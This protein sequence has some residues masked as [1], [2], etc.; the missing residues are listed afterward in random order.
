[1]I[2]RNSA[3]TILL[4]AYLCLLALASVA[5]FE[6][7]RT[8]FRLVDDYGDWRYQEIF[9]SSARLWNWL[10]SQWAFSGAQRFRPFYEFSSALLWILI[11]PRP[12][13]LH[14]IRLALKAAAA[15]FFGVCLFRLSDQK[16]RRILGAAAFFVFLAYFWFFPINPEARLSPQE[17]W[18]WLFLAW[19]NYRLFML[20][21]K[22]QGDLAA[23][24][25]ASW[26][27]FLFLFLLLAT[28]KEV[29]IAF[30]ISILLFL[31]FW[32][33]RSRRPLT[34]WLRLLTLAAALALIALKLVLALTSRS[35]DS[36]G[37]QFMPWPRLLSESILD[38]A[39]FGHRW[40]GF[41]ISGWP[42]VGIVLLA[43]FGLCFFAWRQSSFS[44]AGAFCALLAL[45][46]LC[47]WLILGF[48]QAYGLRYICPLVFPLA[49]M[50]SILCLVFLL[51]MPEA[52]RAG[53]LPL[54]VI[55]SL[56]FVL[57]NY[58]NYMYQF[59]TQYEEGRAEQEQLGVLQKEFEDGRAVTV[60][61]GSGSGGE[62][63]DKIRLYFQEF[64]PRYGGPSYSLQFKMPPT[65]DDYFGYQAQMEGYRLSGS[66]A[67]S[68]E[69][70]P[71]NSR[72]I[73]LR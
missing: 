62:M 41:L 3:K 15:G 68:G 7:L 27:G 9:D 4:L 37:L 55:G 57:F 13:L 39:P 38:L 73:C 67:I 16:E 56:Y 12:W 54:L 2:Q 23:L 33:W 71:W 20:C 44:L 51:R 28:V 50:L 35:V 45:E 36:E 25:L 29:G 30:D 17:P 14:L 18:L 60:E 5:I 19:L 52:W 21:E 34:A 8:P 61:Q 10:S 40:G 63:P 46:F 43:S 70:L 11:G 47:Y 49:G 66:Y 64:L 6:A 26:L 69:D 58:S 31:F 48:T 53:M 1:M 24:N 72:L 22:Y 32:Q 42:F 59:A 65:T